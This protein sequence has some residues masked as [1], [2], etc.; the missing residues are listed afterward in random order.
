MSNGVGMVKRSIVDLAAVSV[1]VVWIA[2]SCCR[3][4]DESEL[5]GAGA[6]LALF[7]NGLTA[8]FDRDL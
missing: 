1:F 8:N 6:H 2:W 7:S 4:A 3:L 5:T